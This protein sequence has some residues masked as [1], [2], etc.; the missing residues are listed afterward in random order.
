MLLDM[1][2]PPSKHEVA[3]ETGGRLTPPL[4]VRQLGLVPYR[5]ALATQE[6]LAA[7]RGADEIPD[8]LLVLEHPPTYTRGRR[9]QPGELPRD[10]DWYAEQGIEI[11]DIDRGGGVTYHGPGQLV[12]YP[13]VNLKPYGVRN[14]VQGL[15][16]AIIA[17]LAD[18]GVGAGVVE[19]LTGVWVARGGKAPEPGATA[20]SVAPAIAQGTLRKIASIG[21]H[22]SRGI[23]THGLA[24][25]V[26]N[27]LTPFEWVV[28]CGIENCTMTS[29]RREE[30]APPKTTVADL[31]ASLARHYAEIF[32]R[33]P[34]T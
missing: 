18:H 24:V 4:A 7:K 33:H 20:A 14:F 31:S 2:S 1:G 21:I 13:I 6:E 23:T 34:V 15:E 19:G 27:D 22:V 3:T 11:V 26:T 10:P 12:V 28:P 16:R 8:T 5:D 32:E 17:A 30:P 25:N 29:V 9:T